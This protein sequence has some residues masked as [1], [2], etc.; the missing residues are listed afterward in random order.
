MTIQ[1][2][3]AALEGAHS[4]IRTIS[5]GIEDRLG[6]LEA[7]LAR[8]HWVGDDRAAYDAHR[9]QWHAAMQRINHVLNEIG[10]AVGAA[11][12]SYLNTERANADAWG[13]GGR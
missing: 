13:G 5:A 2:D 12:E 6:S 1:V 3:F 9:A 10:S 4:Q 8:L 11:R 7:R